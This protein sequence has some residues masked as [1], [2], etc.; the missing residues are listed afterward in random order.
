MSHELVF[1]CWDVVLS[2]HPLKF[3]DQE[4]LFF[5]MMCS[6]QNQDNGPETGENGCSYLDYYAG[7][8]ASQNG[9]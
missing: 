3:A 5:R 6:S 1:H 2:L 4:K 8:N 7:K 9:W